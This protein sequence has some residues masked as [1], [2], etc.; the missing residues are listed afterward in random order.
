MSEIKVNSTGEV[1]LFD[2]D[3]SNYVSIKS[4]ATVSSNQTFVLPDSDGS[5]NNALKTD[6]SG[7][8]GFVDI[9][10]LVTQGLDWQSTLKSS[11]F[12][13]V[14][15]EAYFVNTSGGAVTATLPASPSAGAIVAFKDYAP[16]FASYNLTIARNGSNIQGSAVDSTL[17]TN[18]ASVVLVYIDSTKGWLYVQESNVQN[19]G[20]QYVAA[21]GGT[22]TTSGDFKIHTF[23]GDGTFTVSNA[24]NSSGSNTVDYLVIA[25]GGGGAG[26]WSGGGGAGGYRESFPNPATGGLSVSAQAYPIQVGSGGA[27]GST[28]TRASSG[29]PSIFSSI[30]SAGGG[31]GGADA[32]LT[33]NS[34]GGDG[35]S[36]GGGSLDGSGGAGNT[37]PVSPVQGYPGANGCRSNGLQGGGGGGASE[38]GQV[39]A[40]GDGRASSIN[41][42]PVT[43]GGGGGGARNA[44]TG[45]GGAGGG[46]TG[47]NSGSGGSA[48]TANTGGGGGAMNPPSNGFAG[49]SGVVIIRYKYQN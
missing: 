12:T 2:S 22:E 31:G 48:G 35:G 8:L 17:N 15:G 41:G 29:E 14:S 45:A 11:D 34:N 4:P 44:S 37:P 9:T 20:P 10:T 28:P 49:G 33:P 13:A 3:N 6:G 36:G 1:K 43:R 24:G 26:D 38:P 39:Q 7:N 30:T 27:A 25:G 19:L 21:S 5:A 40:G 16:S 47:S 42:S 23:N 46:G 32:G 18:R